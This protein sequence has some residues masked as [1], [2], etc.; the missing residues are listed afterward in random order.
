MT[1]Q[2]HSIVAGPSREELFDALRLRHEDRTVRVTVEYRTRTA[3]DPQKS[4]AMDYKRI[5]EVSID[6]IEFGNLK[7]HTWV[8]TLTDDDGLSYDAYFD[9]E[10]RQG[11]LKLIEKDNSWITDEDNL[12]GLAVD[13]ELERAEHAMAHGLNRR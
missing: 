7:G 12:P 9:T 4:L 8:L 5:L 10:R 1:N 3:G 11:W 6:S 13:H 2:Q